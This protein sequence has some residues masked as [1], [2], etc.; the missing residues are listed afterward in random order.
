MF[1]FLV[2]NHPNHGCVE[3]SIRDPFGHEK[4]LLKLKLFQSN[5]AV[6]EF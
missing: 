1:I 2:E 4:V 3:I 5:V 6:L